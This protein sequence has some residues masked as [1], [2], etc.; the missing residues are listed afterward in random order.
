M[1][2]LR[3]RYNAPHVRPALC[4][5]D[6]LRRRAHPLL[7]PA[8]THPPAR[9]HALDGRLWL[10]LVRGDAGAARR[11]GRRRRR[12]HAADQLARGPAARRPAAR[13]H[14]GV[15]EG[16]RGGSDR[17]PARAWRPHPHR[18]DPCRGRRAWRRARS[19]GP[20][21]RPAHRLR[22]QRLQRLHPR[23]LRPLAARAAVDAR[24]PGDDVGVQARHRHSR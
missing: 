20:V 18:A 19:E 3:P 22:L 11:V 16:H 4:R 6:H 17:R 21:D 24:S 8:A 12:R 9:G 13:A 14:P 1:A 10:L 2:K 23:E 7:G 15:V 5:S